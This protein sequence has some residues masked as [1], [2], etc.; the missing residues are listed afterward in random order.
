MGTRFDVVLP[1]VDEETA[2]NLLHG[3]Q[4]ELSRIEDKISIYRE[5]SVFSLLNKEAFSSGVFAEPEV[6]ALIDELIS[7]S[8][9]TF[10][11]FDFT[12]GKISK[13][14]NA[15]EMAGESAGKDL[16]D[17]AASGVNQVVL[18]KDS[19]QIH[20][21]SEGVSLDSGGF[22]KGYGLDQVSAL[23]KSGKLR[24]AFVSFGESAILGFGKHPYGASWK[25]GICHLFN[26]SES[27]REFDLLNEVLS[28][29]GN[30]PQNLRKYGRGH[31]INPK[32]K[33]PVEGFSQVAVAGKRGLVAEVISTAMAC[34]PA[35]MREQIAA[36]FPQYRIVIIDYDQLHIPHIEFTSNC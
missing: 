29:S 21:L 20:F 15:T 33:E 11:Y 14:K 35:E 19:R 2:D 24:S 10:G 16:P 26:Q 6:F 27:V 5:D 12:L 9:K 17:S 7:L 31:I 4:A 8:E 25:T 30:T 13:H 36:N 18:D 34:A 32:S 1:E 28:V 3:I 23:L 22:G